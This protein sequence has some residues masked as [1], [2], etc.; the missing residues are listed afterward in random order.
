VQAAV[1]GVYAWAVTVAPTVWNDGEPLAARLA[2]LVAPFFLVFGATLEPR[3]GLPARVFSLWAFVIACGFAWGAAPNELTPLRLDPVRGVAGMLGWALFALASAAGPASRSMA[4]RGAAGSVTSPGA[5]AT[6]IEQPAS[7]WRLDIACVVVGALV[8]AVLQFGGWQI[9]AAEPAL[10]VR[11]V[12]VAAGLAALAL[13]T[14]LAIGRPPAGA[15]RAPGVRSK[16]LRFALMALVALGAVAL[17]RLLFLR[18]G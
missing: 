17:V 6:N 11:F 2:G 9:S 7:R 8:A 18:P 4:S 15:A 13:A 16:Y 1:P 14:N 12:T 10:F 3:V 5:G